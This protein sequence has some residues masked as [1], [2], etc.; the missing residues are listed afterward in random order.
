MRYYNRKRFVVVFT[1]LVC[2]PLGLFSLVAGT[3]GIPGVI[4]GNRP[5]LMGAGLVL[6]L[7]PLT[8]AATMTCYNEQSLPESVPNVV[9]QRT[10]HQLD[11]G[12]RRDGVNRAPNK[13]RPNATDTAL[14]KAA[15]NHRS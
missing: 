4:T 1:S 13:P 6:F 5:E 2:V 12:R 14:L 7:T 11:R 3:V 9:T 15:D 8:I 10:G